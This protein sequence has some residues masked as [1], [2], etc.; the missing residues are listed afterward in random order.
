MQLCLADSV[1]KDNETRLRVS[2]AAIQIRTYATFRL[3][4]FGFPHIFSGIGV[5]N[6]M[7]THTFFVALHEKN[8][9]FSAAGE[10][11]AFP[12]VERRDDGA[13]IQLEGTQG[14]A[15]CVL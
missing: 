3:T 11:S 15:V 1:V 6:L 5:C 12:R 10:C 2:A 4:L 13:S 8:T 9:R 14:V 7:V